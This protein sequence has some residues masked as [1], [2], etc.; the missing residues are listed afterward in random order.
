M[1][2]GGIIVTNSSK[3]A[4]RLKSLRFFGFDK[5]KYTH[6]EVG[7]NSRL[8][9]LQAA[10]LGVKLKK[11]EKMEQAKKKSSKTL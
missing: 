8:D 10:I 4:R 5:D 9:T 7:Y 3:L 2:D 1:G 6:K 11:L